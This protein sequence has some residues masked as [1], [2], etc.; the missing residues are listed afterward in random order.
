MAPHRKGITVLCGVCFSHRT[1]STSLASHLATH[2]LELQET[3]YRAC[4]ANAVIDEPTSV[5]HRCAC[6]S[7][8]RSTYLVGTLD[9]ERSPGKCSLGAVSRSCSKKKTSS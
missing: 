6:E 2:I 3:G 7:A 5:A 8:I 9:T 1:S 4:Q